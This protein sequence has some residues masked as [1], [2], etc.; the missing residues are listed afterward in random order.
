MFFT[1]DIFLWLVSNKLNNTHMSNR[2]SVHFVH[3]VMFVRGNNDKFEKKLQLIT[4]FI[5]FPLF[6]LRS[7]RV[8]KILWKTVSVWNF[9]A[10][11]CRKQVSI[12]KSFQRTLI[13]RLQCSPL[14]IIACGARHTFSPKTKNADMSSEDRHPID[15][16]PTFL[17]LWCH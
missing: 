14:P 5:V 9:E 7:C 6:F 17:P 13:I 3:K 12:F 4:N 10:G 16:R 15:T 1:L 2:L 11:Y 8:F